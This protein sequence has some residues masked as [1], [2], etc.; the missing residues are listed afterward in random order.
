ME[1][2]EQ[3]KTRLLVEI[4]GR[5]ALFINPRRLPKDYQAALELVG[6]AQVDFDGATFRSKHEPRT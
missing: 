4:Q 3:R 2:W 6:K 1:T 5:G